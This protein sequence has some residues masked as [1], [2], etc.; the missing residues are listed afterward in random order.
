MSFKSGVMLRLGK[1][2]EIEKQYNE[3]YLRFSCA[4]NWINYARIN[5]SIGVA[6][7]YEGV[8]AHVKRDDPRLAT[9]GDD[10]VPLNSG[11]SLWCDKGP[12][13]TLYVR[14]AFS[15][16][17]PAICFYSLDVKDVVKHFKVAGKRDE[18]VM[19]D[20]RQY[21]NAMGIDRNEYSILAIYDPWSL[22]KDLR[23]EIPEVIDKAE[24][25]DKHNFQEDNPLAGEY[26]NYDLDI[27]KEFWELY[28]YDELFRKRPEYEKQREARFIIPNATFMRDPVF[29]PDL[30]QDN[31]L[32]VPVPN[33]KKYS[34]IVPASE[35]NTMAFTNISEDL[36][37]WDIGFYKKT[38]EEAQ[39]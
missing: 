1:T 9:L 35:K 23:R 4:A 28:P 6:D 24:N 26:V 38:I 36:G 19:V 2:K 17:V 32:N 20:L 5:P 29:R 37:H 25:I 8:F 15:C 33:I 7:K 10:G 13:D 22:D 34:M 16:L 30:Y 39:G 3:G 27:K 21:Y 14:Y 12:D 11:R 31:E 18:C